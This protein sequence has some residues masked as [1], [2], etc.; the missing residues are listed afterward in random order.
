MNKRINDIRAK[1]RKAQLDLN[2]VEYASLTKAEAIQRLD[3]WIDHQANYYN[4]KGAVASFLRID[5]GGHSDGLTVFSSDDGLETELAP[6]LCFLMGDMVRASMIRAFDMFDFSD[7]VKQ[8][9]RRRM[10]AEMEKAINALEKREENMI[11]Q[12]EADGIHI[13]RR[14]NA[15]PAVVLEWQP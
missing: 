5:S 1:I 8:T 14:H 13:D 7:S 3:A 2:H 10:M 12:A 6:L 11:T 9:E 15:N 4:A